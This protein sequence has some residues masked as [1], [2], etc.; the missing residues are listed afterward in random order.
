MT[1]QPFHLAVTVHDRREYDLPEVGLVAFQ[2]PA[3]GRL[4][5]YRVTREVRENFAAAAA[6]A[7]ATRVRQLQRAGAD[8][9]ELRTDGDWLA[10][11]VQHVTRRRVQ[12]VRGGVI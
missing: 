12:A 11:I 4:V 10:E 5:E 7:R 9:I 6:D 8:V 2:D 1:R 3:T